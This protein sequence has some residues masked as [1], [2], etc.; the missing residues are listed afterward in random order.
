MACEYCKGGRQLYQ[1]TS[2]ANVY[3]NHLGLQR[4]L[5]V[6]CSCCPPYANCCMKDIP[7]RL[8]F[9]IHYCPHCGENVKGEA[10]DENT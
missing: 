7:V 5:E 10:V 2:V 9:L 3:L 6:E 4:T 1:S 8:A